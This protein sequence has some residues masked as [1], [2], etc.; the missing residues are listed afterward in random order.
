METAKQDIFKDILLLSDIDGTLVNAEK[1]I[2]RRNRDA[3]R[4]FI[5]RG[6]RFSLATGR[7][8]PSARPFVEASG[9]NCPAVVMNGAV[10]YDYQK[11]RVVKQRL[12]PGGYREL[13]RKV[14][15][16]FPGIGSE[17]YAGTE[18]LVVVPNEVVE[19]Q[20]AL[21]HLTGRKTGLDSLP[22]QANKLLFGGTHEQLTAM[23]AYLAGMAADGMYG[24]FS[25]PCYYEVLP[26]HTNKGTGAEIIAGFCGTDA[27]NV[28]AVGDYY[29]DEDML[30]AV[31]Y[32]IVAGNAP[33]EVKKYARFVTCDCERGA[34]ADAIAHLE[35]VLTKKGGRLPSA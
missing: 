1:E 14:H 16:R 15:E 3:I 30:K 26:S 28:A 24:M 17:V 13:L 23:Q 10:I 11:G 32:P 34:V 12:L 5:E 8:I 33:D 25:D 9:A 22:E 21:E 27:H 4:R 31:A 29:N 7:C 20:I 6:G 19:S 2:P 35:N 18:L